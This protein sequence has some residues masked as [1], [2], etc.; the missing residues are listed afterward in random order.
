M[1]MVHSKILLYCNIIAVLIIQ[2]G[3]CL[4]QSI[5][6]SLRINPE[7]AIGSTSSKLFSD[8]DYIPLETNKTSL[9]GRI[10]QLYVTSEYFI[11][12]DV[13]TNSILLFRRNGEFHLKI[14]C[15]R[16]TDELKARFFTVDNERKLI[17]VGYYFNKTK[18]YNFEG[19]LQTSEE[20]KNEF[21]YLYLLPD[22]ITVSYALNYNN[23]KY[24]HDS[25]NYAIKVT[26]GD[27]ILQ[28]QLPYLNYNRVIRN[29]DRI[30]GPGNLF[31]ESSNDSSVNL[32]GYYGYTVYSISR[33]N[34]KPA[35][36]Y[37][38]PQEIS[39]PADFLTNSSYY[40]KRIEYLK[41]HPSVIF[42][43][44]N[45]FALNQFI[46]FKLISVKGGASYIYDR[47][48]NLLIATDH[49]ESDSANCYLPITM[50]GSYPSDNFISYSFLTT[51]N[52][53]IYAS[54]SSREM[55]N[56]R[57][58]S[59]DKQVQYS[60]HLKDYFDSSTVNSNPVIIELKPRTHFSY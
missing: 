58:A 46:F 40:G 38:F 33:N 13:D 6:V 26:K 41:N 10:D 23:K 30:S 3:K 22:N 12:L 47:N 24:R 15:G 16:T 17:K 9:F 21:D 52:G 14:K 8:I 2:T 53:K 49:I 48:S 25:I 54:I 32:L 5:P 20:E 55:F 36:N 4:G 60:Q 28:R 59:A 37:I 34:V 45:F 43:V 11:I 31:L 51:Y 39:L 29:E 35:F 27:S 57:K 19:V 44:A 7:E 18:T 42:T 56:A 1:K 50:N